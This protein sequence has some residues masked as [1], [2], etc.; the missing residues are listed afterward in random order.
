MYPHVVMMFYRLHRDRP[1][2]LC[3]MFRAA[4][5]SVATGIFIEQIAI[6]IFY[7]H[8]WHRW[9]LVLTVVGLI[10]HFCFVAAQVHGA[11][12]YWQMAKKMAKEAE[13]KTMGD[14]EKLE[15]EG[16]RAVQDD[17]I[18]DHE[19]EAVEKTMGDR[20]GEGVRAVQEDNKNGHTDAHGVTEVPRAISG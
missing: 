20:E 10:L 2:L 9:S 5:I 11:R 12:L 18:H 17:D 1:R 14:R 4:S 19:K 7:W 6:G 13:E 8:V 15:G 16:V 3:L